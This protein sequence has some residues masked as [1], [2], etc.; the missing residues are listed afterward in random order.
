MTWSQPK[1]TGS[2][3]ALKYQGLSICA[4]RGD[5]ATLASK[6]P[7]IKSKTTSPTWIALLNCWLE[8][9]I[10]TTTDIRMKNSYP[11]QHRSIKQHKNMFNYMKTQFQMMRGP[12]QRLMKK[13]MPRKRRKKKTLNILTPDSPHKWV[14][15][16]SMP[17]ISMMRRLRYRCLPNYKLIRFWKILR[18]K[19][20]YLIRLLASPWS[21]QALCH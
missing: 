7:K 8:K 2:L 6:S 5:V 17:W 9:V 20:R 14:T 4:I 1:W 21:S 13:I 16:T 10:V 19:K 11:Q 18:K 12:H 3:T 15:L